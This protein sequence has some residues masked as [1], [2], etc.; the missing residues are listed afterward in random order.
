M[1][2]DTLPGDEEIEDRGFDELMERVYPNV[3]EHIEF[4][5]KIYQLANKNPFVKYQ[6]LIV[7]KKCRYFRSLVSE[8]YFTFLTIIYHFTTFYTNRSS[9]PP[10]N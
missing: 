2:E 1:S 6:P 8:P 7:L 3:W 10:P 9:K 4:M 5:K